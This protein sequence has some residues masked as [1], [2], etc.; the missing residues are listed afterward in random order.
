M[1]DALKRERPDLA[2]S[3]TED[4]WGYD[5]TWMVGKVRETS[6]TGL[7]VTTW[8]HKY[9]T[10]LSLGPWR[11]PQQVHQKNMLLLEVQ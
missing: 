5:R 4:T 8:T 3:L 2:R 11:V 9:L 6:E 1:L 7:P 10:A